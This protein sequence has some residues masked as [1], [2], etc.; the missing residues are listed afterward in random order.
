MDHYRNPRN[1]GSL[2]GATNSASVYNSLCGDSIQI[3]LRLKDDKVLDAR[4]S[5]ESCAI[6]RS[7]GSLLTEYIKG[8]SKKKLINLNKAFMIK[9]IG[10]EIS[11][12][13]LKCLLLPLEALRKAL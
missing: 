6:A 4:F 1:F 13:R 3:Q 12:V 11:P 7:S 2:R 10:I 9:L 8:K 5:G